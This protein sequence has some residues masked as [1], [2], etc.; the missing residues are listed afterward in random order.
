MPAGA[1]IERTRARLLALADRLSYL[2]APSAI[3]G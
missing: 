1:T 2:G 3:D